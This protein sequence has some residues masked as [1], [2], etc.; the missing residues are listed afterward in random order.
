MKHDR[1]G[2]SRRTVQSYASVVRSFLRYAEGQKWCRLGIADSI[3]APRVYHQE[4]LPSPPYWDDIK[5][6]LA[7]TRT[8]DP[9]D[10]RDYA[11]LLLLSVYGMRRSEVARLKLN[12]IDWK[13]DRIYL[14]RAKRGK[15]QI[16]P[17]SKSVGEAIVLYL[18]EVR[19]EHCKLREV[20]IAMRSPYYALT[21]NAIY[22]IVN[23]R[24]KPLNLPIAHHGPHALRHACATHLINEGFSLKEISD[25]LG[26]QGLETTRIYTK[27]DLVNLRK[28]AE[29]KWEVLS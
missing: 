13:N 24:L 22:A 11:I 17:L 21:P 12:E 7:N 27:V 3:K 18:K 1:D 26:H 23:R 14:K 5:R 20:F 28:V 4:T 19:P 2:Y 8:D 9:T 16:F 6:L 15:P 29:R 25:Y 10:I